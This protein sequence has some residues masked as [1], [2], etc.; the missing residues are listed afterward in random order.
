MLARRPVRL[1]LPALHTTT[2]T[3]KCPVDREFVAPGKQSS[4]FLDCE[5]AGMCVDGC[6]TD[7]ERVHVLRV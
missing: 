1:V 6:P 5:L 3:N 4:P 7:R 2:E